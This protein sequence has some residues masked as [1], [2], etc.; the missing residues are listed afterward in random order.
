MVVRNINLAIKLLWFKFLPH[1]LLAVNTGT[2]FNFPLPHGPH[3]EKE[4]GDKLVP[5]SNLV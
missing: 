2:L 1:R 5:N 4:D 3:G